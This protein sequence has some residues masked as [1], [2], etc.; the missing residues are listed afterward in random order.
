MTAPA[1]VVVAAGM[2][3]DFAAMVR[4]WTTNPASRDFALDECVFVTAMT[5]DEYPATER[6]MNEMILPILRDHC[7]RY[8]QIARAG[9][10]DSSRYEILDDSRSPQ[11]M[12]M[13]GTG[14]ALSHE[15]RSAGTLPQIAH[16]KR[17][18]SY[19]A[20]GQVLDWWIADEIAKGTISAGF[21]HVIGYSAD[22]LYRANRDGTYTQ[23]SRR[24]YYPLIEW[25][26][27]RATCEAFL[28]EWLGHPYP[29][30][31]CVYCPFQ[32]SA[33]SRAE[34]VARWIADPD[35]GAVALELEYSSL[36]LNP[37]M[38]LFGTTTAHGFV[39]DHGLHEV[40]ARAA[41]RLEAATSWTIY[42]VRRVFDAK[43]GDATAKGMAWRSVRP[44][45]TGT[46][47]DM[48]HALTV[49]GANGNRVEQDR[50]GLTRAW[51]RN[52]FH[53]D[54]RDQPVTYPAAEHYYALIPTG[55][56]AKERTGF[57]RKW[58]A[59]TDP[60]LALFT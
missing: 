27:D 57:A 28:E 25:E 22:E 26:W 48:H 16:G 43:K 17:I 41:R 37:R 6:A 1:T 54:H 12:H 32:C 33:K 3:V 52:P 23:N 39:A 56:K 8:V 18:C 44:V 5:G 20:K 50:H 34:L 40:A 42:E 49:L 51:L 46:R 7:V 60:T 4:E 35:A 14:W 15:L 36:G 38:G 11:R 29:R 30:S 13:R 59:V 55:P 31:C 47:G 21:C 24:P 10:P 9:Q 19:R 53:G 2:G 45:M 58:A